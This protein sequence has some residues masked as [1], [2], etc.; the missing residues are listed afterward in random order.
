MT[1]CRSKHLARAHRGKSKEECQGAML[2]SAEDQ[3]HVDCGEVRKA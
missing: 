3:A 2:G 1:L